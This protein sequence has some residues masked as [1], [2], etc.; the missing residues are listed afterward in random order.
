MNM[1]CKMAPVMH[2]VQHQHTSNSPMGKLHAKTV[3]SGD[4]PSEGAELDD[5]VM[6]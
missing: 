3:G 2:S 6:L 1:D 5:E 4:C